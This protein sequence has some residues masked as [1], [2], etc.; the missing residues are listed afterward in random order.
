MP[1]KKYSFTELLKKYT[2]I[3]IKFI[4]TFFKQFKIG[5]ELEFHIYDTDVAKYLNVTVDNI[6]RRLKN[7][8]SKDKNYFEKVD[9]VRVKT[10]IKNNVTYMLNYQCFERL[11]MN[12]DSAK[13]DTVRSYFIKLREFLYRNQQIINQA[14]DNYAELRQYSKFSTIYFFAID[15]RKDTYKLGTTTDIINRLRVYNVG[16][17]KDVELKYLALVKNGLL[18]ENCM[19][20]K[21]EKNQVKDGREIYEVEPTQIKKIIDECYCKNISKVENDELYQ[22]LAELLDLYSYVK[23]KV[24]IKPY[25]VIGQNIGNEL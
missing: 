19:K 22:E 6:R 1:K 5:H 21:L 20:L 13:S 15:D 10:G 11:A 14:L 25:I 2:T 18:I 16:R 17:I 3:D 4:D 23:N 7:E 12:G 9:Y 24:N 8:Y